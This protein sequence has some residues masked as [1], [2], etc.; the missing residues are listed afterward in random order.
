MP[1]IIIPTLDALG[2]YKSSPAQ[3]LK[4][5]EAEDYLV[6]VDNYRFLRKLSQTILA[7]QTSFTYSTTL[8]NAREIKRL[9]TTSSYGYGYDTS[10]IIITPD[11]EPADPDTSV[12]LTFSWT[13]G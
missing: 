2:A 4:D 3:L 5:K 7:G 1:S 8:G 9:L 6:N 13:Y 12:V 10:N 11:P